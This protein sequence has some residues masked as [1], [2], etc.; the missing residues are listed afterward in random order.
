MNVWHHQWTTLRNL[1]QLLVRAENWENATILLGA[2]D[3]RS[4]ASPPFGNDADVMDAA[5]TRLDQVL[6]TTRWHTARALGAAMT[7]EEAVAFACHAI[8]SAQA[9]LRAPQQDC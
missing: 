4:T 9:S 2:I 1:V 3:A 5:A 8:D 6:G 7:P